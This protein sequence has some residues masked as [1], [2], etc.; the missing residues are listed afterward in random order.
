M[1]T[2]AR[3]KPSGCAIAAVAL[4]RF[5]PAAPGESIVHGA[6][7]PGGLAGGDGDV[8]PWIDAVRSRG[9]ERVVC[10]LSERQLRRYHALLDAYRREFC[11]DAVTHVP[12]T[13]HALAEED[14]LRAALE[15]LR[16]ADDADEPVVVHCLVGLGRT[17]HVLAAWLVHARGYE[18]AAA[19]ETVRDTERRPAEAVS[20]GNATREELLALLRSVARVREG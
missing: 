6:A 1:E 14:Q 9:I 20:A 5:G 16:A 2:D 19:I 18:P 3:L 13:D 8:D 11:A 12:M 15:A 17:G 4:E 10:L 7:T